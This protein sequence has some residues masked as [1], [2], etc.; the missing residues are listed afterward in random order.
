MTREV[1]QV[2]AHLDDR[3]HRPLFRQL[4]M[5][6][7]GLRSGIDALID[8]EIEIAMKGRPA[9]ILL[10]LNSLEDREMVRKLYHAS[11]VGVEVRLIIRGICCLATE[12]PGLS[13]RIEAI[14][15]VDR[16]LEHTR[17]YVF[18][19]DGR[20]L[21]YLSSADLMGRNLDHRVEVAFPITDPRLKQE[22]LELL[23][24]Q[25]RDRVKAR[26]IDRAQENPYRPASG[27]GKSVRAQAAIQQ[28]LA[29]ADRS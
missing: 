8:N 13:D 16:Y 3:K 10:K 6:P 24:L 14:S 1:A 20:P 21:V 2:F 12:V 11:N 15:I 27:S 25:W 5:A 26:V 23:D 28:Y 29:E 4:M 22:V 9:S 7:T 18:G 19:N 17:A